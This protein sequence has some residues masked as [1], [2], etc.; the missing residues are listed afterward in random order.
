MRIILDMTK[1]QIKA[2]DSAYEKAGDCSVVFCKKPL[3]V[4]RLVYAQP[5]YT[6]RG[7]IPGQ[8]KVDFVCEDCSKKMARWLKAQYRPTRKG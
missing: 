5:M 8:L 3:G 6:K 4:A 2:V 1:K 7:L